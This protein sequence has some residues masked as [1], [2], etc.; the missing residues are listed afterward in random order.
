MSVCGAS[1]R[2]V[3]IFKNKV[4]KFLSDKQLEALKQELQLQLLRRGFTAPIAEIRETETISETKNCLEFET[5][6]LQTTPVIFKKVT[7]GNFSSSVTRGAHI[8][9]WI[10]VHAFWTSFSRGTNGTSLFSFHAKFSDDD[11]KHSVEP[12]N[13][14]VSSR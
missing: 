6:P 5:Q 14:E 7:V 10:D 13:V 4:M 11:S 9:V 3:L 1:R 2:V 12:F 8:E